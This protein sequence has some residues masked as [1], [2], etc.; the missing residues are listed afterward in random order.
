MRLSGI[1]RRL[2][3]TLVLVALALC[4]RRWGVP[5]RPGYYPRRAPGQ[6][7]ALILT[8]LVSTIAVWVLGVRMRHRIK[9]VLGI[10]V[11]NEEELTSLNTWMKVEDAEEQSKGGNVSLP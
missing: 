11:H 7:I 6:T 2:L 1:F 9:R 4:W 10:K 8:I 5:L 3:T